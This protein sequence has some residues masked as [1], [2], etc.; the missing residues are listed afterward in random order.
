MANGMNILK[1]NGY[2]TLLFISMKVLERRGKVI[3]H[4]NNILF[5]KPGHANKLSSIKQLYLLHICLL[6][7]SRH[8]PCV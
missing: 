8:N 2:I 7:F 4:F 3:E 1:E 5:H 6:C